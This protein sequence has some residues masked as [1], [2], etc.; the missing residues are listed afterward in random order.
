[1]SKKQ[2]NCTLKRTSIGGQALIEGVMMRGVSEYAVAVR[3]KDGTIHVETHPN[4]PVRWYNKMPVVRGMVNMFQSLILGYR[5]LSLSHHRLSH[6][7]APQG[8]HFQHE[9]LCRPQG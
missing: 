6:R 3:K 4:K 2:A 7:K 8:N 1:M 9:T 5:C